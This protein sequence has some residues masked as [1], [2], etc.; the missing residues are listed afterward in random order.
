MCMLG[1]TTYTTIIMSKTSRCVLGVSPVMEFDNKHALGVD[2]MFANVLMKNWRQAIDNLSVSTFF[3]VRA[4][5][6]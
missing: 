1:N 3:Q 5:A 4:M 2:M 6:Y